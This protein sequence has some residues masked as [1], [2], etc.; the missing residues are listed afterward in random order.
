MG[1]VRSVANLMTFPP[2]DNESKPGGR[3]FNYPH[4]VH[5]N[6][7]HGPLGAVG[8]LGD[9]QHHH[10]TAGEAMTDTT[11]AHGRHEALLEVM[12]SVSNL[13]RSQDDLSILV[14]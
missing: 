8:R 12:K 3:E 4:L 10:T 11:G 1:Y 5:G 2:Q 14:R 13:I 9:G 7:S 6:I